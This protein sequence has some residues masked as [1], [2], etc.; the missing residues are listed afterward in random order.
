[1]TTI[2][3]LIGFSQGFMSPLFG[4]ATAVTFIVMLDANGLRKAVGEHANR[5]NSI[6]K[7]TGLEILRESM[8]H[9][10]IE[11]A[12]GL[13]LGTILGYVLYLIFL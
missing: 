5:I 8:G 9:T 7:D 4:L 13:I 11:I 6:Q 3:M 12:G 1:M 2:T 10:V